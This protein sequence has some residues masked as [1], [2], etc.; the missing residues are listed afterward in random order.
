[1]SMQNDEEE[2]ENTPTK[3]TAYAA[4]VRLSFITAG[5]V[6]AALYL[7]S[8]YGRIRLGN[9]YYPY[10][11]IS[12]LG[13]FGVTVYIEEIYGLFGRS[14]DLDF[15]ESVKVTLKEW[16]RPIGLVLIGTVYLFIIDIVGFFSASGLAMIALMLVG[17]SRDTKQIVGVTLLVL[18][19]VYVLFVRLMGLQPPEGMF[20]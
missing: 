10:F 9:L 19:L 20:I 5:F 15:V 11:V 1:M 8:T 4:V 7:E 12:L 18:V 13:L 3:S 17:G 16:R 14:P 6:L 2:G